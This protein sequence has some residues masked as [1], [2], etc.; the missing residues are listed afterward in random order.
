[1]PFSITGPATL[2][3]LNN[4]LHRPW[5]MGKGEFA[6]QPSIVCLRCDVEHL[7]KCIAQAKV[8]NLDVVAVIE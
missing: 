6:L 3:R 8:N 4:H 2:I 1:M 7:L 5:D